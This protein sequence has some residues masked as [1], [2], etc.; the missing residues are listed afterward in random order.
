MGNLLGR[1]SKR[2]TR[3][4]LLSSQWGP[5]RT[6]V[7]DSSQGKIF[8]DAAVSELSGLVQEIRQMRLKSRVNHH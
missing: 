8:Y 5:W 1:K 7:G 6:T 3:T 4:V 2:L